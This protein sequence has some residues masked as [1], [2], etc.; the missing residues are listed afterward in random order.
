M[1]N[2]Q[3]NTKVSALP[4]MI[5]AALA[6][7][8]FRVMES[9]CGKSSS[10]NFSEKPEYPMENWGTTEEH[11]FDRNHPYLKSC[12]EARTLAEE[13]GVFC[14]KNGIDPRNSGLIQGL[15]FKSNFEEKFEAG[16]EVKCEVLSPA[17]L[18]E[19]V[20]KRNVLYWAGW[21][22]T[23]G[24]LDFVDDLYGQVQY[25]RPLVARRDGEEVILWMPGEPKARAREAY[26]MLTGTTFQGIDELGEDDPH[27]AEYAW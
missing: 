3:A 12:D 7:A 27:P 1:L 8:H 19:A 21:R 23:A 20:A 14:R 9:I 25:C 11:R 22:I 24:R 17:V 5:Q 16:R 15:R 26:R 10:S 18:L 4:L 2:N 6:D 13:L